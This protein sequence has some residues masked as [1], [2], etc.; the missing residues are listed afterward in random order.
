MRM[1]EPEWGQAE[2]RDAERNS[3]I[4]KLEGV[5]KKLYLLLLVGMR[6]A[7]VAKSGQL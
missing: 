2:G 1:H 6:L 3:G 5:L 7:G 4:L